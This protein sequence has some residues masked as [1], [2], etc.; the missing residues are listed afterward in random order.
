MRAADIACRCNGNKSVELLAVRRLS[1]AEGAVRQATRPIRAGYQAIGLVGG[2]AVRSG[3]V[4]VASMGCSRD[5]HE[6]VPV[7]D[8][9]DNA[10]VTDADSK[11][12]SASQPLGAR[13]SRIDSQSVD[14]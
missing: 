4:D 2:L 10:V 5:D 9:I 11:V 6:P 13:G 3:P 7:V 1:E 12:V 14:R 8:D